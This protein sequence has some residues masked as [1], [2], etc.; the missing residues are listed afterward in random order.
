MCQICMK[1]LAGKECYQK[2]RADYKGCSVPG[3]KVDHNTLL[4]WALTVASKV[5]SKSYLTGGSCST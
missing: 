2:V 3:R 1:N 4:H 5:A